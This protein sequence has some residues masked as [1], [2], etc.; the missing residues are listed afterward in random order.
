MISV[1]LD[2]FKR[3]NDAYGH[4]AGDLALQKIAMVLKTHTRGQDV[5]CRYGGEE[6][7]LVMSDAPLE[8]AR[9]RAEALREAIGSL[10][11]EYKTQFIAITASFGVAAFPDAG[12]DRGQ[13]LKAADG[14][15]YEAKNGGRNR[16]VTANPVAG[17]SP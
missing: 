2:D 11:I 3:I 14:A 16:V 17:G 6:F 5:A 10:A 15:L 9:R 4:D 12:A 13:L 1:D 8:V 7:L